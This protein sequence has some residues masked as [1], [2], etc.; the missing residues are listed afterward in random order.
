M[1]LRSKL[2]VGLGFLFV[3]ILAITVYSSLQI[4]KLSKEANTILRDN[5]DSLVYCKNMLIAIDD[6]N[7]T[8]SNK[9]FGPNQKKTSVYDSNLFEQSKSSFENSLNAEKNN[10]T[11]VS[12]K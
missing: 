9:I 7:L 6:I 2:T 8:V 4:E 11:E 1:S 10:I 12:E 3:I 5:Y